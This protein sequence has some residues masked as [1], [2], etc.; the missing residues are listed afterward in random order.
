MTRDSRVRVLCVDDHAFLVEGLRA[1]IEVEPDLEFVGRLPTASD[2]VAH[3]ERTGA[4]IVLLDIEMPGADAFDA[5]DE[6]RRRFPEVKTILLSAYVRDQY[7]DAAYKAG[8]WGYLSKSDSPDAVIDGIR[9]VSGGDLAFSAEVVARS[10]PFTKKKGV[11]TAPAGSKRGLLT[12]RERQILRMIAKGM[13]RTEIAEQLCRS[14]MTVDNHRKSIMK[15]LGLHDRVDLVRY[16]I[17][18]GLG[19][20]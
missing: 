12:T 8:A 17:A 2:L 9:K 16:A 5:M 19:E 7:I 18:E 14:P 20:V 6:L 1:R 10:Q 15:K 4:D 3:V 11:R 13:S